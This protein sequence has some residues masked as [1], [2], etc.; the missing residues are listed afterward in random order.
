MQTESARSVT[1]T[2]ASPHCGHGHRRPHSRRRQQLRLRHLSTRRQHLSMVACNGVAAAAGL[3]CEQ[4]AHHHGSLSCHARLG[5]RAGAVRPAHDA[6]THRATTTTVVHVRRRLRVSQ[7]WVERPTI[8]GARAANLEAH[9][10][11]D[12]LDGYFFAGGHSF[13]DMRPPRYSWLDRWLKK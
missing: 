13:P 1:R 12:H 7:R 2:A 11:A 5:G 8:T 6:R 4:P 10:A 3:L 9:G